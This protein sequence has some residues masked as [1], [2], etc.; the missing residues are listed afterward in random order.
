MHVHNGGPLVMDEVSGDHLVLCHSQDALQEARV[1]MLKPHLHCMLVC[2]EMQVTAQQQGLRS[3]W[4][5]AKQQKGRTNSLSHIA[6]AEQMIRGNTGGRTEA[7]NPQ[8]WFK[9]HR[10]HSVFATMH[11]GSEQQQLRARITTGHRAWGAFISTCMQ[12]GGRGGGTA[13]SRQ[14]EE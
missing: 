5:L 7:A 14:Q 12:Q 11:V 1:H 6:R 10:F 2:S 3:R 8:G 9:R 4:C 13:A